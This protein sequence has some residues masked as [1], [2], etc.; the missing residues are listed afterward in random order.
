MSSAGFSYVR[1]QGMS[2][3][4]K[5]ILSDKPANAF[6]SIMD[7]MGQRKKKKALLFRPLRT[8]SDDTGFDDGGAAGVEPAIV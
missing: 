5:V 3:S 1:I 8:V 7:V 6:I 4:G 2:V